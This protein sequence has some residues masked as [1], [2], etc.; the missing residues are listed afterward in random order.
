MLFVGRTRQTT[1]DTASGMHQTAEKY[2]FGDDILAC[3]EMI[4]AALRASM[5]YQT[6]GLDKKAVSYRYDFFVSNLKF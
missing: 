6:G 4:Y 5:I 3:G 1:Q 2:T